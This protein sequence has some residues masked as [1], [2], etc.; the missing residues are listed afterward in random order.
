MERRTLLLIASILVAAL[1][2]ALVWLY[3]QGADQRAQQGQARVQVY[4][5][6]T[7]FD[8]NTPAATVQGRA[9]L[10]SF[11]Q[12]SLQGV[13][14]LVRNFN[15]IADQRTKTA[16]VPGLPLL[17]AQFSEA[18]GAPEAPVAL[19]AD[20]LAFQVQLGDPQRVAGVLRP[21]SSVAVFAA[22][23]DGKSPASMRAFAVLENVRVLAAEGATGAP[24]RT[25]TQ[26][27][28]ARSA[29]EE[30]PK[31]SV[32]LEVSQEQAKKLVLAQAQ[33]G[34]VNTLWFALRGDKAD[35][36]TGL[37]SGIDMRGLLTGETSE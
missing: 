15:Q 23:G 36:S 12:E 21:G 11:S 13:S 8:A 16:I 33:G 31:S 26:G 28:A 6:T 37:S 35:V 17:E 25:Q 34:A 3:V 9:Q 1:G 24:A 32:T 29:T 19:S 27:R 7:A 5:A 18:G 4:V 14:G 2:T 30:V 20:M 22:T 10:K